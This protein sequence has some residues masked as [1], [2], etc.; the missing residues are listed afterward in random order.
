MSHNSLTDTQRHVLE[1][2]FD[3]SE[4]RTEWFPASAKVLQGL[5]NRSLIALDGEHHLVGEAGYEAL[6]RELP[7]P[8]AA[9]AT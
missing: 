8:M 5:L 6:G 9:E 1:D 2:V 7:A 3:D 4:G